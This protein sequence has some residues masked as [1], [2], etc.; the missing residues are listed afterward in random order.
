M[1]AW[2]RWLLVVPAVFV[3]WHLAIVAGMLLLAVAESFC[4]AEQMVSGMCIAGWFR[5]AETII[6]LFSAGLAAVLVIVAAVLTAPAHRVR[7]AVFTFLA[8]CLL[9]AWFALAAGAVKEALAAVVC[10]LLTVLFIA[11][12]ERIRPGQG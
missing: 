9:A 3:A 8:G 1:P 6:F 2:L 4:P 5:L 7:V 11:R 12:R 10:G